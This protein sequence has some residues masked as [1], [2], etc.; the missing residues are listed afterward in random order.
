MGITKEIKETILCTIN[1]KNYVAVEDKDGYV[2]LAEKTEKGYLI[3]S[4]ETHTAKEMRILRKAIKDATPAI[5]TIN[6][7]VRAK[8]R[9]R[10]SVDDEIGNLRVPES[11]KAAEWRAYAEECVA[12]GREEKAKLGL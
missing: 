6:A 11:E 12:W 5:Q 8:I 7:Q 9:E 1:D 10:Y 3:I 4:G 2:Q